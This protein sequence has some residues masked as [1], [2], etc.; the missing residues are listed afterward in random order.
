MCVCTC[1]SARP[2]GKLKD[3]AD[4][5]IMLNSVFLLAQN[6]VKLSSIFRQAVSGYRI[7]LNARLFFGRQFRAIK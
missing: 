5:E 1:V 4:H 2:Q 6:K 7:R 3:V